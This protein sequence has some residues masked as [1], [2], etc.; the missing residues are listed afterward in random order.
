LAEESTKG[1][2]EWKLILFHGVDDRVF[3]DRVLEV[4]IGLG[5]RVGDLWGFVI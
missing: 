4:E 5:L 3:D 1:F 2:E